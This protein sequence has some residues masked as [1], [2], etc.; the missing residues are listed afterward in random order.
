MGRVET[1]PPAANMQGWI[2]G[3]RNNFRLPAGLL[4]NPDP[5][6]VAAS[7]KLPV[8]AY[9]KFGTPG[10]FLAD[11]AA[12]LKPLWD[13]GIRN[14]Y[15]GLRPLRHDL[16]KF[17]NEA[18][19]AANEVAEYVAANVPPEHN[20][21][22]ALR[23]AEYAIAVCGLV[24]VCNPSG[25]V[26]ADIVLGD[27]GPLATGRQRPQYQARTD[28]HSGTLRFRHVTPR[29]TV[30]QTIW[31]QDKWLELPENHPLITPARRE[32][33]SRAVRAIPPYPPAEVRGAREP[34]RYEAAVVD[35][36]GLLTPVFVDAQPDYLIT[37]V[38]GGP[39]LHPYAT[40]EPDLY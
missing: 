21:F 8:P 35:R 5:Y 20:G 18:P 7:M 30:A 13:K 25:S 17:R 12:G 22:Y 29:A 1:E 33:I 19:M 38:K 37:D 31:A 34:G 14:Y 10:D 6:A 16:P 3:L 36:A 39:G 26:H 27:L 2:V 9:R 4:E 32:A 28:R 40:P 15:V 24:I 11:T 23:V